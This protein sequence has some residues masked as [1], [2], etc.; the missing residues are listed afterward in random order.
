MTGGTHKAGGMLMSI[1]GFA[2]LKNNNLLAQDV[3][4]GLQ[5]LVIYPFCMWG[6]VASDLDHNPNAIP[7]KDYPSKLVN[8]ALHITKPIE[9]VTEGNKKSFLYKVARFFNARHRSWQTHSDLTLGVMIFLL[10]NLL[11]VQTLG[12]FSITDLVILRLVLMGICIGVLTLIS[13]FI[14]L[15][16]FTEKAST[17]AFVTISTAQLF[18]AY[19]CRSTKSIFSKNIFKNK[20]LNSSF[21]VGILLEVAVI[22]SDGLND[23]FSLKKLAINELLIAMG[24]A[25]SIIIIVEIYKKIINRPK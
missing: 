22:Y 19:N 25:F 24:I 12:N 15:T 18:H 1:V 5:W 3:N 2:L 10:Y 23:V 6:S 14:G 13:Y 7:M 4:L 9:D 21:I 17:M 20:L 16:Y 8:K 11:T